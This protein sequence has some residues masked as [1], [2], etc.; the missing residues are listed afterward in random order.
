MKKVPK[1]QYG[2]AGR[3]GMGF[4]RMTFGDSHFFVFLDNEKNLNLTLDK[5]PATHTDGAGGFLTAYK[6]NDATGKMN[7]FSIFN[8][9]S[10]NGIE[11]YQFTTSRI[12]SLPNNQFVVE[13]YKKKK[14]DILIKV[15]LK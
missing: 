2:H 10:V 3:G 4:E 6:L 5:A 7:S 9:R 11:I 8:T 13:A 14:E 12:L 15:T 1:R